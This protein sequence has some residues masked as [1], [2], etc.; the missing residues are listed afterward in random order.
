MSHISN[1]DLAYQQ[2]VLNDIKVIEL[3]I[4]FRYKYD[5][6]YFLSDG[7]I[8]DVTG[9]KAINQEV[10]ATYVSLDRL[11][12]QCK[13]SEQQLLLIKMVE[14]GYTHREIE[15]AVG[16]ENQNVSKALKTIYKAIARENE[17][18]WRKVT[19]TKTLGL[20]TK[21]CSDCKEHLPATDEFFPSRSKIIGDGFYNYCKKCEN[22]RKKS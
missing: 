9:E 12:Q 3:L 18:Q 1:K 2:F 11:I 13:F 22:I 15:K 19:Y 5:E 4:E 8:L 14:Q 20:K 16:I 7:S 21:Q 17:R 6:N 10:I